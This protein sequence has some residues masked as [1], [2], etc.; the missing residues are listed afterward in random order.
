MAT[1]DY[2]LFL[3]NDDALSPY[4]LFEIAQ[5]I[6]EKPE[7]DIVYYDEDIML[8]NDLRVKPLLKPDWSPET[9][10]A[11]MYVAH[12]AYRRSL[13]N[14]LGGMRK[15]FEGSQDYDLILRA[16]DLTDK[17]EHISKVLYHWRRIPGSTADFYEAKTSPE[18]VAIKALK[19]SVKRRKLKAKV[20]K[21]LT[22]P[23]FRFKYKIDG[24]PLVSIIIPT[25]NM[26]KYLKQCI[27]S[28]VDKTAYKNYEIIIVDNQSDDEETLKYFDKI[29]SEKIRILNY[30]DEFNYSAINNFAVKQAKG[31]HVLLLNNDTKVINPDWLESMLEFSQQ[32]EIGAVGAL[33]YFPDETIQHAGCAIGIGGVA[34][35]LYKYSRMGEHHMNVSLDFPKIIHNV[36]A[37][38]GA[39]LM[40]KKDIYLEVGGLEE[41]RLKVAFNDIDFCLKVTEKGYRNIYTPFAS[42]YHYESKSRGYE[43]EDPTQQ[44]RFEREVMYFLDRWRKFLGKG[45]PYYNPNFTRENEFGEL[46]K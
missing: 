35:H 30:D 4:A 34:G 31:S 17:I 12:A 46:R 39:C 16:R 36:S 44:F 29:R 19:E 14:K 45:D 25:R 38:T 5:R 13:V 42:L 23:S 41:K 20:E 22:A 15:G 24:N 33:L 32:N 7:T 26:K 21:G 9:L 27:N 37:V 8:M 6:N 1:G 28:V 43:Y 2:V 10:D 40:I 18:K 11:T 3:D